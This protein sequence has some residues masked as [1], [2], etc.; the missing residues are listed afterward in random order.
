MGLIFDVLTGLETNAIQREKITALEKRFAELETENT[1][2]KK[3]ITG[4]P[5]C[6]SLNW[7]IDSIQAD[8]VFGE[9]G[10]NSVVWKCP[11]CD[12]SKRVIETA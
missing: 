3:R 1:E 10:G 6:R 9:L 5:R 8:P 11:D 7:H 4:C 12:L 2:L